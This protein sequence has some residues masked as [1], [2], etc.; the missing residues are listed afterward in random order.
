V[1]VAIDQR[2]VVEVL[3]EA[4]VEVLQVISQ[5]DSLATGS[6]T[7]DARE[8]A[9]RVSDYVEWILPMH[10]AD[11]DASLAPR[12]KGRHQVVDDA[13]EQMTRQHFALQAPLARLRLLCRTV[14]RDVS[15]LHALRFE[16]GAAAEDLRARLLTHQA[17]EESLVFPALKRL[18]Y[19][20][21]LES[22]HAEMCARRG[23]QAA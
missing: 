5:A 9:E 11:E 21:E 6:A 8:T 10:C 3:L 12:L 17:L 4:H 1:T 2:D 23:A 16:I 20:D 14:A 19:L 15:R 7:P 13:L 18:L 22:I